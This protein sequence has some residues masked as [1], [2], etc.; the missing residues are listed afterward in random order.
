MKDTLTVRNLLCLFVLMF[1]FCMYAIGIIDINE[2]VY[3]V[4][5][6]SV[7]DF[8]MLFYQED[9]YDVL[10]YVLEKFPVPENFPISEEIRYL[11]TSIHRDEIRY[12]TLLIDHGADIMWEIAEQYPIIIHLFTYLSANTIHDVLVYLP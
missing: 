3:T 10:K 8:R 11:A 6:N 1:P 5:D 4:K 9:S 12:Y 7:S 2:D